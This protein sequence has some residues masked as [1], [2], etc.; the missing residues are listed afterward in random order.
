MTTIDRTSTRADA[1]QELLDRDSREVPAT[2]RFVSTLRSGPLRVGVDRYVDPE[3]HR[4]EVQQVWKRVWQMACRESDLP[5]VG[6]HLNYEICGIQLLVTRSAPDRIQAFH[7]VCLHRGRQLKE[8][9]GRAEEFR[10]PFHG[11]AWNLDGSL[12]HIPCR[13]DFGH[14]GEEWP[15]GEVK[16]GFWG[17]FVFVNLDPDAAPPEEHLD[18]LTEQFEAWPPRGPVHRG[19]RRQGPAVQLEAGAGSVHGVVPRHGDPPT[20]PAGH[21]RHHHPVR[22]L[23]QLEAASRRTG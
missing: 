2:Y 3:F 16:V 7:N 22:R 4:R 15:L 20:A 5:E 14:V 19:S 1:Y 9:D 18:G 8:H 13:W 10:C 17:G 12:K 23:R 6:D 11:L 21:G